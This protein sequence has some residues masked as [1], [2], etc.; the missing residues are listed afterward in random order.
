MFTIRPRFFL[1]SRARKS[2][3][4]RGSNSSFFF[5]YVLLLL[6][7]L[8][9]CI[10]SSQSSQ[11]DAAT[12]STSLSDGQNEISHVDTMPVDAMIVPRAS[13][14]KDALLLPSIFVFSLLLF[15]YIPNLGEILSNFLCEFFMLD[16]FRAFFKYIY[17]CI[18][19]ENQGMVLETLNTD[20]DNDHFITYKI[21]RCVK[22]TMVEVTRRKYLNESQTVMGVILLCILYGIISFF[23]TNNE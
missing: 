13:S 19:H 6:L 12:N 17:A 4:M 8:I 2:I 9:N 21:D 10:Y 22:R 23:V 18:F 20:N 3:R 11:T 1:T 5:L 7:V 14:W 16:H 15:C